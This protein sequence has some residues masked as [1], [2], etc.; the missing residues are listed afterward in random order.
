M[1]IL[2]V[3]YKSPLDSHRESKITDRVIH[4]GGWLQG[5]ESSRPGEDIVRLFF[6]F[7]DLETAEEAASALRVQGEHVEGPVDSA[8]LAVD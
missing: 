1:F 7:H 2:E 4:Q 3:H 6:E 8:P 5:R